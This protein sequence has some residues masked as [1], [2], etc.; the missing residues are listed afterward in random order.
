[1]SARCE[2]WIVAVPLALLAVL[3]AF[4]VAL[5]AMDVI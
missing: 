1:M 2:T 3:A 4:T 5:Y